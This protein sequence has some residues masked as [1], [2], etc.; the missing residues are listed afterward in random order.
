ME[1]SDKTEETIAEIILT[2]ITKKQRALRST[3]R[4]ERFRGFDDRF[5]PYQPESYKPRTGWESDRQQNRFEG[6]RNGYGPND[7]ERHDQ[8]QAPRGHGREVWPKQISNRENS[9]G[10]FQSGPQFQ[11]NRNGQ[12]YASQQGRSQWQRGTGKNN[13]LPGGQPQQVSHRNMEVPQEP[14]KPPACYNWADRIL[15]A[16]HSTNGWRTTGR[17]HVNLEQGVQDMADLSIFVIEFGINENNYSAM[18]LSVAD[19][20]ITGVLTQRVK[21]TIGLKA[22]TDLGLGDLIDGQHHWQLELP[23]APIFKVMEKLPST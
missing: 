4:G 3:Q 18:T 19:R 22:I 17:Q 21:S 16:V 13:H 10:R 20:L 8:W 7:R 9:G 23:G 12:Q 2:Q 14:P 5:P 11:G 6:Q 1:S 15:D